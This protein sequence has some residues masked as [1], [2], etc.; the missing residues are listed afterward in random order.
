MVGADG[1]PHPGP[2]QDG[3]VLHGEAAQ[4]RLAPVHEKGPGDDGYPFLCQKVRDEV[5][6]GAV[7]HGE[8][9]AELL[10]QPDGGD[11]VVRPVG[12]EVGGQAACHHRAQGVQ[13][14]IKAGA[15]CLGPVGVIVQRLGQRLPDHGGGGHAGGGAVALVD[16]L[17]V[18]PQGE[19][20]G[21]GGQYRHLV[22]NRA[23]GFEQDGLSGDGV[24]GA[25]AGVNAGHPRP[26]GL[27]EILVEGVHPVQGPELGGAGG[28]GLVQIVL[29]GDGAVQ[30]QVTVGVDEAGEDVSPP[31]VYE[32]VRPGVLG[33][34]GHGA[35][36]GDAPALDVDEALG[37]DPCF[38]GVDHA[39]DNEHCYAS[40]V[41]IRR[42][43]ARRCGMLY[44]RH[45]PRHGT[46]PMRSFHSPAQ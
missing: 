38:H 7:D 23:H 24:G 17:G 9:Q 16:A 46:V 4:L 26:A 2:G 22:H 32:A 20:H 14:G 19:L 41:R 43:F 28:G 5:A 15:V 6:L 25:G 37:D 21:G 29:L 12:V 36:P 34:I 44:L 31:G 1:H 39:V 10:G 42:A 40:P 8:I 18:L 13:P 11:D 45:R 27:L 33:Q 30:P 3:G 35:G